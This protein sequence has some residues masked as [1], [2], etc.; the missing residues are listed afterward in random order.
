MRRPQLC[1]NQAV[2]G[3]LT[4]HGFF[5]RRRVLSSSMSSRRMP[6]KGK[7][8]K[9]KLNAS[10]AVLSHGATQ[11]PLVRVDTYNDEMRDP[12][13]FVGDRAS[14]RAFHVILAELRERVRRVGEDPLGSADN[15]KKKKLDK[16]LVEG[17][18][19]EAGLVQSVIEEFAQEFATVVRRFLRS[20]AWRDTQCIVVG[21]GLRENPAPRG[22]TR[23]APGLLQGAGSRNDRQTIRHH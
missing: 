8:E 11:L 16:L 12:D 18:P 10:P 4:D 19:E 14:N 13:G 3:P 5:P 21:G 17:D 2:T 20:K 22:G 9:L 7:G 23:P 15:V 6:R 1:R